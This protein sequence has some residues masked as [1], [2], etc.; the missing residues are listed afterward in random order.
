[1]YMN[2]GDWIENLTAL[3]YHNGKWEIFSY[4]ENKDKL[5]LR[6]EEETTEMTLEELISSVT[7]LN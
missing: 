7:S 6:K 1:M 5:G 2:S 4:E 3:E